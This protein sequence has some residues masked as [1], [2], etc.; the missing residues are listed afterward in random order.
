MPVTVTPHGL[1]IDGRIVPIYSGTIHYWRLDPDLW[2]PILENVRALGFHMIETYIPWAVHE[3]A[4]C[5]FDFGKHDPQKNVP[6]FLELCHELGIAVCVRPGP[7]INAELTWFGFPL[8]VLSDPGVWARTA[9]GAPA[10]TDRLPQPFAIPSYASEKLFAEMAT[11]FDALCPILTPYLAPDGPIVAC[12]VDNEMC[13]FF[14][15]NAYD[16]D[17]SADS[18]R[19]YRRMLTERYGTVEA[20]NAAYRGLYPDFESVEP[21]RDF[22]ATSQAD[23]P[24]HLDWVAYKEYQ[25]TA[26]LERIGTMLRERGI[27]VPLYHDVAFQISTPIDMAALESQPHLDLVGTNLYANQEEFATIATRIRYQVGSQRLPFVPEYGAGLWWFH[28]RTHTAPEEEFTV[29]SGLMYGLKALNFYMLVERDRWQGSPITRHNERRAGYADFFERLSA[30]ITN[31]DLLQTDKVCRA[32]VLFNYELAR[33]SAASSTLQ[34]GYLGLLEVPPALGKI[35]VDLGYACD[36]GE[37]NDMRNPK[38]WLRQ[39]WEAL[40][41]AQV[42]FNLS[43]THAAPGILTRYPLVIVPTADFMDIAEQQRLIDYAHNGGHLVIGPLVPTLDRLMRPASAL[44]RYLEHPDTV[45]AGKGWITWLTDPT[46]L[47]KFLTPEYVNQVT[48]DNPALRL[49]IRASDKITL[50]FVANPTEHEQ[51]AILRSP[52]PLHGLWNAPPTDPGKQPL[53]FPP[54]T[55]SIWQA[56]P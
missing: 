22:E 24:R 6:R 36:P 32:L 47:S 11:Y 2:L 27:S 37:P 55:V 10:I 54:Y 9:T 43:D 4:P 45:Q 19:L 18:L 15:T 28:P 35:H 34:H 8:R 17:Y 42:E 25:I 40:E 50:C 13:Y 44:G 1:N 56:L 16:L 38:S 5:Y 39:V 20:L 12:Q 31:T 21:P 49:T 51:Q 33:F 52:K 48:F 26:A 41:T 23:V 29:L 7:H 3:T 14:R 46:E 30:L 53:V